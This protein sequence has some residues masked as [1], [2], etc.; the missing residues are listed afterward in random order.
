MRG[1]VI[2]LHDVAPA[3]AGESARWRDLVAERTP[4]PVSLLVVPRYHG[5]PGWRAGPGLRWLRERD[6]AGDEPVLH[7][8]A[9]LDRAGHDG[10]ELR[11]RPPRDIGARVREGRAELGEAG[12]DARGF[13]APAY[14]HPPA[15]DRACRAAGLAWWATRLTLRGPGATRPLPSIG[16]GASTPLVRRVSP[17][18]ARA[19][20]RAL[21]HAP[22]VRLDL[23]PADLRHRALARTGLELLDILLAQ[24]RRPLTH[25]ALTDPP[26]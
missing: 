1:L 14:A 26:A 23:H 5:G 16:L 3:T 11:G 9:H 20:A 4:G 7:G 19:A 22:V 12:L 15:A 17:P 18:A 8:Y 2:A 13:I 24:G 10:A 21:V 6:A 25:A